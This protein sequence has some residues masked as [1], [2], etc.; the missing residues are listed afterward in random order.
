MADKFPKT[1][2]LAQNL[3][4]KYPDRW[5][6]F[7]PDQF[8]QMTDSISKVESGDKNIPQAN[9]GP[10][11]GYYQMEIGTVPTALK[12]LFNYKNILQDPKL[13]VPTPRN[14]DVSTLNKDDQATLM[15]SN[16]AAKYAA[17]SKINPKVPVLSPLDSKNAWLN[18]HW[19]GDPVAK[20]A[21][22]TH[23]DETFPKK[24]KDG[25]SIK[26]SYNSNL[27]NQDLKF[28]DWYSKNT[29]EGK[30]NIPYSTN[31]DYDYYSFYKN[32]D[33][34]NIINHFPDTYKR[35]N[36]STFSN[37][38]IYSTPENPG[39]YWSGNT[40]NKNGDFIYKQGGQIMKRKHRAG[41]P[42][43]TPNPPGMSNGPWMQRNGMEFEEGGSTDYLM[44]NPGVVYTNGY[45]PK[46]N[47]GGVLG[48][49]LSSASPFLS[50]IPG[51]GLVAAPLA[52]MIGA[53]LQKDNQPKPEYA[54]GGPVNEQIPIEVQGN[55]Q[56]QGTEYSLNKGE[57]LVSPT[58]KVLKNYIGGQRH[59]N[60]G[61]KV[62]ESPGNIVIP[63]NQSQQ[64]MNQGFQERKQMIASLKSKQDQKA[65]KA[66]D[67]LK[68]AGHLNLQFYLKGGK[69]CMEEGGELETLSNQLQ[70]FAAGGWIQGAVNPAH[71]RY[72]TPMSKSTCTP[73]RKAFAMT[74]KKYHGF[75]EDGGQVYADGGNVSWLDNLNSGF[76]SGYRTE[77]NGNT[78]MYGLGD[79]PQFNMVQ[80]LPKNQN[81]VPEANSPWYNRKMNSIP[82]YNAPRTSLADNIR[83]FS[84][85][86]TSGMDFDK[87]NKY[88]ALMQL[89]SIANNLI[90]SFQP[91][92]TIHPKQV[93]IGGP[94][95]IS[96][97]TGRREGLGA[98][99]TGKQQLNGNLPGITALNSMYQGQEADRTLKIGNAN[100]SIYNQWLAQKLGAD[101]F[102]SQQDLEAQKT[103]LGG[104]AMA[105]SY[106]GQALADI[107]K[108]SQNYINNDFYNNWLNKHV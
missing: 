59:K 45:F 17:D 57:L 33:K 63:I 83:G 71:K 44:P 3:I 41:L 47:F 106:R 12:R 8:I 21:R 108:V 80:S 67:T 100:S 6:K 10:G 73:R 82:S 76:N 62:Q 65:N 95:Y 50:A 72:C 20:Q 40:Y 16:M 28:Q 5:G 25:G 79:Q 68:E 61:Y 36:H 4:N 85:K 90:E 32:Q 69:I 91:V 26:K 56:Q 55:N 103:T 58:G 1:R 52:G 39:G 81:S 77:A 35:P 14:N 101:Q 64:Y 2:R 105:R 19:A 53:Q 66:L 23:W 15:L 13:Q 48:S 92:E 7:T 98:Y 49:I 54:Q 60:G 37:E 87:A 75:H 9:Q 102:N 43:I 78:G 18:Y 96:P 42:V 74:M 97:N 46:Y 24:Y 51:G 93:N 104:K 107:G 86:R 88:G 11:K 30:N 84:Q 22:S 29:I 94:Q 31:L 34:G 99:R 89:P 27:A 70:E 38:S